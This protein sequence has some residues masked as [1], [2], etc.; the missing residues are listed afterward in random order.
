MTSRYPFS[1]SDL[2]SF[3]FSVIKKFASEINERYSS[4]LKTLVF[5]M[6]E[7]DSTK[8][9]ALNQILSNPLIFIL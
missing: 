9:I 1:G 8:R 4:E 6:L 3:M 2:A 5:L 7:K